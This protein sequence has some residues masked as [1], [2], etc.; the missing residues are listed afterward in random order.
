MTSDYECKTCNKVFEYVRPPYTKF[1]EKVPCPEC[2][3]EENVSRIYGFM[4]MGV[5]GYDKATGQYFA[6][7]LTPTNKIPDLPKYPEYTEDP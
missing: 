4:A 6:A 2:K 5:G 7:G 1:P 3:S